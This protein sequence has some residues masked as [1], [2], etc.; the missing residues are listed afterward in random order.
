LLE[1]THLP[2]VSLLPIA[3]TFRNSCNFADNTTLTVSEFMDLKKVL[4]LSTN[5]AC[6][7][8]MA[9]GWMSYYGKGA[10]EVKSAGISKGS[11]DW[12]AANA[13]MEAVIDITKYT[14]KSI[15]EIKDFTPDFVIILSEEAEQAKD[16]LTG[17]PQIIVH[18][19]PT[20]PAEPTVREA[21]YRALCNE[22]ENFCFDFVN[23]H[24]KKLV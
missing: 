13:M 20:T 10:I 5:N 18:H 23:E 21:F 22:M 12:E 24:V 17:N 6:R 1:D 2:H 4:L 15:E 14:S 9:E 8:Q 3:T 11:L 16:N 7:S 19:F